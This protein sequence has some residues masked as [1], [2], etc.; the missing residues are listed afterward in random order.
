MRILID[1]HILLW[2][3]EGNTQLKPSWREIL[4]S[5]YSLKMVSMVSLWEIAIKTNIKKLSISYPLDKLVPLDFQILEIE[6]PHFLAYQELPL[7]HKDPF[8]RLL[9]AQAQIEDLKI[10]TIDPNFPLYDV[11]LVK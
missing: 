3:V 11:E 6:M 10:M 4:Q 2:Y 1:T 9:I 8:D 5:P 7:H